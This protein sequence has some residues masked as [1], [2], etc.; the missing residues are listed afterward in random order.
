[1][2]SSPDTLHF[3]WEQKEES[4]KIEILEHLGQNFSISWFTGKKIQFQGRGTEKN[5]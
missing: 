2:N 3:I 4:V 1:M 5:K